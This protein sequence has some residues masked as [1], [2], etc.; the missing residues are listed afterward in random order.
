MTRFLCFVFMFCAFIEP[1][2]AGHSEALRYLPV[3]DAGRIKPF[4]TFAREALELIHGKSH[5]KKRDAVQ[6]VTTWMVNSDEWDKMDLFEL[7]F[8]G[9][10]EALQLPSDRILYSGNELLTNPRLPVLI[11]D[12]KTQVEQG[13]KLNPYYQAVQRLENQISLYQAIKMGAAVRVVP[14]PDPEAWI[15]VQEL[16]EPHFSAFRRVA[17]A[18][19]K[20]LSDDSGAESELQAAVAQFKTEA[21]AVSPN[22]YA[23]ELKI[24]AEV[25]YNHFHPLKWAWIVYLLA[26]LSFVS[27]MINGRPMWNRL[28]WIATLTGLLLHTY[29]MGLRVYLAGR[30]PVS[31][32]YETVVWVPWGS[33]IFA[34]LIYRLNKQ[35]VV[36]ITGLAVAILCLILTDLA[37]TVLD[38]TLQPLE[39]VLRSNF[40]LAT[41]VTIITISYAAFFLAFALADWMLFLFI[42]DEK[43]FA[44]QISQGVHSIYRAIQIGVIL[45]AIGIILGGIWADYSW[46]RFWGW[47]PKETWALIALLGYVAVLHGRLSG[48]IR[49]FGMVASSVL[50]FS[51]VM[52]SWYGVNFWLGAG[53]HTYGFGAGGFEY[54]LGFVVAHVLYVIFAFTVRRSRAGVAA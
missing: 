14:R 44:A 34:Y 1:S 27:F 45:L 53:L 3:Q 12:L 51:L 35:T 38:K 6:V 40:W 23:D 42:K 32:M 2:N 25:H 50:A 33:L 37:P 54:V 5:F 36:L 29:S 20:T 15:A 46:G 10:R 47:D 19:I 49:N 16:K 21:R 52:M 9:L 13:V 7:R 24:K 4:D 8:S 11:Q 22:D 41:H 39:P 31:N 30:P 26:A 18:F 17:E 43:K 28:G 48:Y